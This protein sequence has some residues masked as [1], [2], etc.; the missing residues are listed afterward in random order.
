MT[1]LH[2]TT[3][4]PPHPEPPEP[5]FPESP[6]GTGSLLVRA[7]LHNVVQ[8]FMVAAPLTRMV[9]KVA[10]I[11]LGALREAW[12]HP[13][14]LPITRFNSEVSPHRVYE[15]RRF[16]LDEFKKIR[17]LVPGA[18]INDS[19]LAV[20]GGALRRYLLTH[21]ELPGPS[22]VSIAPL[23]IR[24]ADNVAGGASGISLLRVPLGT[25]LEDPVRRLRAIHQHTSN[26]DEMGQAVGAKELTDITKHAPATTLALSAR[27]LAGSALGMRKGAPLASCTVTNVPGP[28]IPLYLNGARMTYFSAIMPI[29]DGMGL[30]FAV[31]SYD[32]RIIISPTSCREQIPDPEFFALCI[33][34]SFQE[35]LELASRAA[36]GGRK[37][38][39]KRRKAKVPAKGKGPGLR[40]RAA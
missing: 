12:L 33:R 35:Y 36:P 8:P 23:S 39:A 3:A 9:R 4:L 2:D 27:L 13:D 14:R 25:E 38:R 37:A 32:G 20:C 34:E 31:T 11:M 19:V 30:V 21:D 16:T 15:S 10:P 28:A 40:R 22:L 24:N 18:T 29:S 5:W 7:A 26:A 6:P 17:S 1:L